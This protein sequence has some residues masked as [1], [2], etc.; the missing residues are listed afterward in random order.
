[1][2]SQKSNDTSDSYSTT[3]DL[4]MIRPITCLTRIPPERTHKAIIGAIVVLL[5]QMEVIITIQTQT[6][7]IITKIVT[8]QPIIMMVTETPNILHLLKIRE[9]HIEGCF[10]KT[11]F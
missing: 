2:S 8:D 6:P 3:Q 4:I 11:S 9:L 7:L 10:G 1:M 5:K